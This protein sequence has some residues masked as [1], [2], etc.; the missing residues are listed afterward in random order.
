MNPLTKEFYQ[1]FEALRLQTSE[2]HSSHSEESLEV[3]LGGPFTLLKPGT[4]EKLGGRLKKPFPAAL[5]SGHKH[6]K[7]LDSSLEEVKTITPEKTVSMTAMYPDCICGRSQTKFVGIASDGV[8]ICD[9]EGKL[10]HTIMTLEYNRI[11]IRTSV[12]E[13]R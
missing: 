10:L 1:A 12:S 9:L 5:V 4:L 8:F 2:K 7:I 13:D 3:K 11:S 6:S